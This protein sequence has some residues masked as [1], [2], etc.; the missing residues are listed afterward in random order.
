MLR[1]TEAYRHLLLVAA[2]T[3]GMMSVHLSAVFINVALP[4][5]MHEI[6][7]PLEN[8][9]WLVTSYIVLSTLFMLLANSFLHRFGERNTFLGAQAIF[10][11]TSLFASFLHDFELILVCRLIQ[12]S[13]TGVLT[14]LVLSALFKRYPISKRGKAGAIYGLVSAVAPTMGPT[15]A[16]F[17]VEYWGWRAI[18]WVPMLVSMLAFIVA[19]AVL[20]KH[21]EDKIAPQPVAIN[22]GSFLLM[23]V[24]VIWLVGAGKIASWFGIEM[25]AL[26]YVTIAAGLIVAMVKWE[27]RS[28]NAMFHFYLFRRNRYAM[29]AIVA[30]IYGLGLWG[31]AY[32]LPLFLQSGLGYSAESTGWILLPS[33]LILY[34]MLPIGGKLTDLSS[35]GL[36]LLLGLCA[37][38]ISFSLL[39]F[40]FAIQH[41]LLLAAVIALGRGFGMGV[42]IPSM[43]AVATKLL[44]EKDLANG[45]ALVNFLRQL[46][47]A[48]GPGVVVLLMTFPVELSTSDTSGH[49]TARQF[50]FALSGIGILFFV[51][52]FPAWFCRQ[53]PK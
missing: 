7:A 41:S 42:M 31:A 12:G 50:Q 19:W 48:L 23:T 4:S 24:I 44:P 22:S 17:L 18:F 32:I 53:T 27:R 13:T 6:D 3:V 20:E 5:M 35:G 40:E 11:V 34:A 1:V 9:Y 28:A 38:A 52:L 16:G 8:G 30:F 45:L 2:L 39:G 29:A 21:T 14:V 51:S 46:G 15:L 33:G 26:L 25:T 47:G 37:L 43:D 10:I 49:W 36:A